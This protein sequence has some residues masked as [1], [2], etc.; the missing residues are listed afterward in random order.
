M[1]RIVEE[2]AMDAATDRAIKVGLCA[3]F[4]NDAATFSQTRAWHGSAATYSVLIE[5][6]GA[7]VAHVG[8]VVRTITASGTPVAM[9]GPQNVYVI[10]T[11]R[12]RGLVNR[13]MAASMEE[14]KRRGLDVG[15]LFCLPSLENIYKRCG[16]R[17]LPATTVHA[18]RT[19]GERYV[20]DEHNLLMF[21]PLKVQAFPPGEIDLNGDDW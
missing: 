19:N 6:S 21:Y 8:V 17:T 11:R 9:A 16:W 7:V 3:S 13:V 1:L 12:G 18:T 5:E 4:P 10:P 15:L 20:L 14:A 2:S